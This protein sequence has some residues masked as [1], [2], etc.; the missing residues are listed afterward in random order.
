MDIYIPYTYLI[1]WSNQQKF[2]YGCRYAINCNPND[3]W[4]NYFT[5]SSKVDQ[6][7]K[8]FGDP[9][10]IQIRKIFPNNPK[11]CLEWEH[12]FLTKIDAANNPNFLNESNGGI[13]WSNNKGR[14]VVK[15]FKGKRFQ[16]EINDPRYLSGELLPLHQGKIASDE[17]RKK[18]SE[19]RK[20]R[21]SP[22]KGKKLTQEQIERIT[23]RLKG[24]SLSEDH[25]QK[26]R[27]PRN[28]KEV[29]CPK[30]GKCGKGPNMTR[31]H[32]DNCGISRNKIDCPNCGK[33]IEGLGNL[34]QHIR[35]IYCEK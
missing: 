19:K 14:V 15:D 17:T 12:K 25:K 4:I 27:K 32:F 28:Q 18:M 29:T 1:G 31:Y 7:I 16:V 20:G 11:K 33:K 23:N 10:I 5:S 9:D 6:F 26:L 34:K 3:F 24:R 2:Y 21:V 22:N 30:C 8:Q 13:G 35:S